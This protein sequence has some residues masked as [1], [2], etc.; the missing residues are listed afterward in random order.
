MDR[1][2]RLCIQCKAEVAEAHRVSTTTMWVRRVLVLGGGYGFPVAWV[3][4][5]FVNTFFPTWQNLAVGII[6]AFFMLTV[7]FVAFTYLADWLHQRR[8]L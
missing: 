1:R 3:I 2:A 7:W 8:L 6:G 4:Y 5:R